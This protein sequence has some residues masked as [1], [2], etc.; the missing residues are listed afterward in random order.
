[1]TKRNYDT[2]LI[3]HVLNLLLTAENVEM[4][5]EPTQ[6]VVSGFKDSKKIEMYLSLYNPELRYVLSRGEKRTIEATAYVD[7]VKAFG[8]HRIE[9]EDYLEI[10]AVLAQLAKQREKKFTGADAWNFLKLD[11]VEGELTRI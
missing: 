1:M 5:E 3:L 8:G 7:D 6:I 2:N 4:K 10:N 9:P 11:E